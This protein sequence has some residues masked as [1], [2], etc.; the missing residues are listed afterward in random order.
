MKAMSRQAGRQAAYL[1]LIDSECRLYLTNFELDKRVSIK[2]Y[3]KIVQFD[4]GSN[5]FDWLQYEYVL[6]VTS[7]S[8][9]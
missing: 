1:I 3:D 5:L 8:C 6:R 7:L 9:S 4:K 2:G